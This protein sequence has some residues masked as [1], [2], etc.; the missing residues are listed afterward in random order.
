MP[1][2]PAIEIRRQTPAAG[3]DSEAGR[4]FYQE[5]LAFWLKIGLIISSTFFLVGT[6]LSP[7]Y[8]PLYREADVA[9][10]PGPALHLLTLLVMG[11]VLAVCRR[12]RLSVRAL[13]LLDATVVVVTLAGFGAGLFFSPPVV[14]EKMRYTVVLTAMCLLVGRA[15]FVPST[16]HRTLWVSLGGSALVL[17][18]IVATASGKLPGT[19]FG[20]VQ[21]A[22]TVWTGLWLLSAVGIASVTSAA[23]YGLRQEVR[24]ARQLGQ[25]T[26]RERLGAG[27]M[28]VVYKASH[29]M[30]RRP[31]AVKLLPPDRSGETAVA[32]FER[33]VQLTASLT[34][35]NTVAVYDYGRTPDGVFYYAMEYLEG[36]DLAVLVEEDGPQPPARV[37]HVL[38][39]VVGALGEA[40]GVGLIHRD[41]KAANV[42]LCQRGGVYDVAKVV[43]F[44]LVKDLDAAESVALTQAQTIAGTPQYLAPEVLTSPDRVDARVDL[45]ALGC[46]GYLLLTGTPL[47]EGRTSVEVCSHHLHTAPEPP[48]RRLGRGLPPDLEGVVL[49]CVEKDPTRRPRD[50]VELGRA[51]EACRG[52]GGWDQ[53]AAAAW[54]D[55]RGRQIR[56]RRARRAIEKGDGPPTLSVDLQARLPSARPAW[57][58]R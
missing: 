10:W 28:G 22:D 40:H 24:Q 2:R 25:Y 20:E 53:A 48:S 27:G 3:L 17:G 21:A 39:Q 11:A 23:I 6:L 4:A 36:I 56:E 58:W 43:D 5:R 37:R 12:R 1:S 46:V 55:G 31:T 19:P 34:H 14:L 8:R 57:P 38:L 9:S 45:Y 51:L 54:W 29:A 52:V 13:D 16:S 7:L 18:A 50:A 49:G 26:L 44:G 35:P 47:F 42:I 15:A 30:L 33:E 32:R 41:V